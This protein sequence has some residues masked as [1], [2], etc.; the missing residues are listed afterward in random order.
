MTVLSLDFETASKADLRKAGAS[1][2]A[3][4]FS[5]VVLCLA[6][7]FDNGPVRHVS[8]GVASLVTPVPTAVDDHIRSG[9]EIHAWNAAFEMAIIQHTLGIPVKAKQFVC[10]MQRSLY[11]GFPARLEDAAS[12]MALP[13]AKDMEGYRLMMKMCKPRKDGSFWHDDPAEGPTMLARLGAYCMSDVIAER[14][15]G[16]QLP[17]LP[18]MEQKVS[19][20]DRLTNGRGVR[21]DLELVHAFIR[22]A[23]EETAL[24]DRECAALTKG[25]VTKPGTQVKRLVD[26]LEAHGCKLDKVD[27]ATVMETL[28]TAFDAE[29]PDDVCRVLAIRREVAKSSLGKLKAMIACVEDDERV[30][31]T[32]QYYGAGRTG[33]FSGRLIQPQ[34][35]PRPSKAIPIRDIVPYVKTAPAKEATET[36]RTFWAT[37]LEAVARCLRGTIIPGPGEKLL[38]FD[39]SQIEA[40][41]LAWLAGQDDILKVFANGEDVYTYTKDRLGLPHRDAGKVVVLGLGY[42]TG[43][44]K[45]VELAKG[46]GLTLSPEES[47]TIVNDWRRANSHIVRFWHDLD[48]AARA[49]IQNPRGPVSIHHTRMSLH[50]HANRDRMTI[51]LP[52]G[53]MLYYRNPRLEYDPVKSRDAIVFDGIDQTSKKWVPIR[54]WGA[55]LAENV[56]QAIAR[57]V[58]AEA[59]LRVEKTGTGELVLSVHDELVWEVPETGAVACMLIAK[60]LVELLP[61]W[62]EGLPVACEGGLMDRY[63]LK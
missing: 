25:A 4:N 16:H 27:K 46:Y 18:P 50:V 26:W 15:A 56:T 36:L 40:R 17:D 52:S 6:W 30:R 31:G 60:R 21:L 9:G 10:T 38:V 1:A 12:A 59:A 44:K 39:F 57:D 48:D 13:V 14:A 24:L 33:R 55:K 35:F 29:L 32:L 22:I 28:E 20:L 8:R 11:A 49:A 34:N 54:T 23:Q 43:W 63:G 5:T 2:Y 58:M 45:F 62:A 41:V 47:E 19:L 51:Q 42:G 61:A 7:A 53:R 3:K 37:P